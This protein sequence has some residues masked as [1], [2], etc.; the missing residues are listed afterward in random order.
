MRQANPKEEII[1]DIYKS[2]AI[3]E[4]DITGVSVQAVPNPSNGTFKIYLKNIDK[5][6]LEVFDVSGRVVLKSAFFKQNILDIN[7]RSMAKGTYFL[8]VNNEKAPLFRK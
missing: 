7:M 5:G 3:N 2:S 6:Y 4:T 1:T 8:K